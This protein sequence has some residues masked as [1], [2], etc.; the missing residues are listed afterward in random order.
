V[1]TISLIIHVT[2]A[3]ILIGPQLLLFFAVIPATWLIED[4]RLKRDVTRVVTGRYGMLA[5]VALIALLVTGLY[6][7]Y[8]I[9]PEAIQEGMADFRFGTI[10]ITKMTLFLALVLLIGYHVFGISRQIRRLSD[11]VVS[12]AG[13]DV[14]SQLESKRRTSFIFSFLILLV[15][16]GI[17][18]LGVMLGHHEFSYVPAG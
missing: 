1:E 3:A 6:Q 13:A 17:L 9:V 5:G 16:L 11:R 10:F 18:V 12:G 15:S 2:A 8:A 4:E 7:F 14:A